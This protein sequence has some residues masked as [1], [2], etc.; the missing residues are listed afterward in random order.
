MSQSADFE[1]KYG[2]VSKKVKT[3]FY[4]TLHDEGK[5]THTNQYGARV[6]GREVGCAEGGMPGS[7]VTKTPLPR[8]INTCKLNAAR[9]V[10]WSVACWAAET[11]GL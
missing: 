7:H 6:L 2:R 5:T 4:K 9:K 1:Q 8:E 3:I 10:V 11:R